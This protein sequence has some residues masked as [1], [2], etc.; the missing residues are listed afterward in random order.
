[1]QKKNRSYTN[2]SDF[3]VFLYYFFSSEEGSGDVLIVLEAKALACVCV[4]VRVYRGAYYFYVCI[5]FP[6]FEQTKLFSL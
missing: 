5:L 3:S 1:M 4:C 2:K 6:I